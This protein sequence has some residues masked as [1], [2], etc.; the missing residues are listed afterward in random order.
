MTENAG[1]SDLF[2]FLSRSSG[3]EP[4]GLLIPKT[5]DGRVLFL[6]PWEGHALLGTTDRP[7][8]K[9][10]EHGSLPGKEPYTTYTLAG[11]DEDVH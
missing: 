2:S 10:I 3:E 11:R 5:K 8:Q 9:N 6:L 1:S 4:V 7:L